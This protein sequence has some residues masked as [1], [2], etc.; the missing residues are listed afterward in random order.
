[1][2]RL[3]CTSGVGEIVTWKWA[4]LGRFTRPPLPP[5]HTHWAPQVPA[6]QVLLHAG[7][8]PRRGRGAAEG[9]P[10]GGVCVCMCVCVYVCACVCPCVCMLM[11][12]CAQLRERGCRARPHDTSRAV[13]RYPILPVP[14]LDGSLTPRGPG[15]CPRS[16]TAP[17]ACFCLGKCTR[18]AVGGPGPRTCSAL[19]SLRTGSY[20]KWVAACFHLPTPQLPGPGSTW[21]CGLVLCCPGVPTR[22]C[23]PWE[24]T[25][26]RRCSLP[27]TPPVWPLF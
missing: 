6:R 9:H 26:T 14:A 20:G 3:W 19:R 12:V 21:R 1:M 2:G 8:V 15:T 24:W 27:P 22:S 10:A 23:V 4:G 16:P 7:A 18:P 5:P 25:W 17:Q 11:D 13:S